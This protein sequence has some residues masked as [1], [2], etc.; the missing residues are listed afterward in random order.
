MSATTRTIQATPSL[1]RWLALAAVVVLTALIVVLSYAQLT[2]T[3]VATT[4]PA[5]GPAPTE[6][7]D[8]GWSSAPILVQRDVRDLGWTSTTPLVLPADNVD[9]ITDGSGLRRRR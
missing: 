6:V 1:G 5:A 4:A 9:P 7:H 8:H 2:S 3:Q